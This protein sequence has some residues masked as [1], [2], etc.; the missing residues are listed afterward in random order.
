MPSRGKRAWFQYAQTASAAQS[1]L[2]IYALLFHMQCA[3]SMYIVLISWLALRTGGD[4]TS[5]GKVLICWQVLALTV[6]P[7]AGHLID[8]T[9]RRRAFAAGEMIHASGVAVL[10]LIVWAYG[11]QPTPLAVLYATASFVSLGSLLSYPS[12]QALL[13][14]AGAAAL[15][16]AVSRGI[17]AGQAGN[18]VGAAI[19]GLC[20]AALSMT[21]CL[22]VCAGFSLV[23]ATL[24]SLVNDND[25]LGA[26]SHGAHG[27][28]LAQGLSQ[29]LANPHIRISG[30]ALI[31]AFASAHASNALLAAFTRFDLNLSSETY[32]FL[33]AMYSGGGVLGSV[34]LS[35][36][37]NRTTERL[38]IAVGTV[39]LAAATAGFSSAHTPIEALFWQGAIGLSFTIVRAGCDVTIL[40]TVPTRM[41]GR[42]RSN[43]DAAI[44]VAAVAVYLLPTLL[45]GFAARDMFVGLSLAFACG[46]GLILW[47]QWRAAKADLP[48]PGGDSKVI[49]PS[50]SCVRPRD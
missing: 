50:P 14:R 32:G 41:V 29:T 45:H 10:G 6:G 1:I 2:P 23:A 3:R 36:L 48:Q 46:S 24:T 8:R 33:A 27:R 5:V 28:D 4:V 11:P 35:G 30:C 34:V 9:R 25:D 49:S 26:R 38:L 47:L 39:F 17:L 37:C 40:K 16:R 18:I 12:S 42:V 13:Q 20:L 43:I 7:F 44:G 22:L 31:L 19:G 15:M 21:A